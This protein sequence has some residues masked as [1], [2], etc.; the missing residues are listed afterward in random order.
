[1]TLPVSEARHDETSCSMCRFTCRASLR[2]RRRLD[3]FPYALLPAVLLAGSLGT[4]VHGMDGSPSALALI[5]IHRLLLRAAPAP[6][7]YDDFAPSTCVDSLSKLLETFPAGA[8]LRIRL[9]NARVIEGPLAETSLDSQLLFDDVHE[10][11]FDLHDISALW[12]YSVVG[13]KG[14]TA[15]AV[16]G[17]RCRT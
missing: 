11:S 9:R 3:S 7:A 5:P 6:A 1:M 14:T 10:T 2:W 4:E 12:Q 13:H 16:L 8:L 17:A 15:G